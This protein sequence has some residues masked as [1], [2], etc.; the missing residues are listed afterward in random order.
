MVKILSILSFLILAIGFM[1][2]SFQVGRYFAKQS[3]VPIVLNLSDSNDCAVYKELVHELIEPTDRI[4]IINDYKE[5]T[6]K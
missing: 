3:E 5:Y 1:Y 4:E 2:M 6:N